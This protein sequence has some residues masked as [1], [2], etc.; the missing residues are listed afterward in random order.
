MKLRLSLL[1]AIVL[2]TQLYAIR[3]YVDGYRMYIRYVKHIPRYG[4]KAPDL[5]KQ[6]NVR[7]EEDLDK[8]FEN[9]G[10]LLIEKTAQF[11]PKAAEGLKKIIKRGKI[12][13]LKVFLSNILTG[14][15]PAG[16]M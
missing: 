14:R 3:P 1:I 2:S 5:L 12:K 4:I 13:Q 15:I 16:C 6:L 10:K 8:L 9:N 11:N 7:T